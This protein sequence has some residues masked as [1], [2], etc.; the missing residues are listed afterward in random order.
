MAKGKI[1]QIIGPVVDFAF[2]PEE[3]PKIL[4][5]V[6]IENGGKKLVIEIEQHL[7]DG[8]VR[9]IAMESTDGLTRGGEANSTG[10]TIS[11]PVGERVLG[12]L[13]N[14]LGDPIDNLGPIDAKRWEIHRPAPG[15]D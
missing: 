5:T 12:R 2:N 6:E 4:E 15:F 7:G 10:H 9:G 11:V 1:T 8:Q 13:L 14:V 3:L